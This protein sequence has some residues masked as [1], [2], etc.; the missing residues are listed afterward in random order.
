MY[1]VPCNEWV[2]SVTRQYDA[3]TNVGEDSMDCGKRCTSHRRP[4]FAERHSQK[5]ANRTFLARVHAK[6]RARKSSLQNRDVIHEAQP[7]S[8]SHGASRGRGGGRGAE[9]KT[10]KSLILTMI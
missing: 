7:R 3:E 8:A 2:S 1:R 5:I 9:A 10:L 6:I 4:K